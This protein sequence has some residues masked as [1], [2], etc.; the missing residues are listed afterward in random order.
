MEHIISKPEG[1]I[2]AGKA[3]FTV[4]NEKTGN[5]FT[6]KVNQAEDKPVWFVKVLNGSNN[7]SDYAYIGFINGESFKWTAK[8]RV[9]PEAQSFKVFSWLWEHIKSL[10]ENVKVYHEGKC[11]RCGRTLT[12]PDSIES[13]FG[14][15]CIH[16]IMGG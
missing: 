9:K 7:D 6:F 15:E 2:K 1:F 12:V 13:G 16:K 5:R 11:G 14:P 8:S 4:V 10:P 3:L